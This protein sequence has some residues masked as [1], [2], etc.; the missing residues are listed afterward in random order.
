MILGRKEYELNSEDY[1]LG[2]LILYLD[3][4]MMF[5]YLLKILG[6]LNKN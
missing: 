5:I 6:E 3:V 2:A 1:I 4:I